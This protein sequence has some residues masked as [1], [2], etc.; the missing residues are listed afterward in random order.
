MGTEKFIAVWSEIVGKDWDKLMEAQR[1]IFLTPLCGNK[2]KTRLSYAGLT[3][4]LA[5]SGIKA[6]REI[7]AGKFQA[8]D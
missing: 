5:D 1:E 8:F 4:I 6:I 3:S 2:D 7:N